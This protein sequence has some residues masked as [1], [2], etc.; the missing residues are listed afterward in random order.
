MAEVVRPSF[1][2]SKNSVIN[3]NRMKME[4][5]RPQ[6]KLAIYLLIFFD[7]LLL[8]AQSVLLV[9]FCP[10]DTTM[11]LI[12]GSSQLLTLVIFIWQLRI[13]F[14]TLSFEF[15]SLKKAQCE[16]V[17]A[18][19]IRVLISVIHAIAVILI[20][21]LQKTITLEIVIL[22]FTSILFCG[23]MT[24]GMFSQVYQWSFYLFSTRFLRRQD[25]Q[26][27]PSKSQIPARPESTYSNVPL[28]R[29]PHQLRRTGITVASPVPLEMMIS[30]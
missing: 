11:Q 6:I 19:V 26:Q 28:A 9:F 7:S 15:V 23:I 21:I 22:V 27:L 12:T 18:V 2:I 30:I 1:S 5:V 25:G 24:A 4:L 16:Q 17:V 8:I 3:W 29:Q 10:D 20:N 14:K 13:Y